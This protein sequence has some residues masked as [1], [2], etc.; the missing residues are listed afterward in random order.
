MTVSRSASLT[1]TSIAGSR[2][3]HVRSA[4]V[5][6]SIAWTYR[7]PRPAASKATPCPRRNDLEAQR[8]L[9]VNVTRHPP[10]RKS[11]QRDRPTHGAAN[12]M[13]HFAP[14]CHVPHPAT[15]T[16][17]VQAQRA[18]QRPVLSTFCRRNIRQLRQDHAR[19]P[20]GGEQREYEGGLHL[21]I[22]CA[23]RMLRH[24][25]Q[26]AASLA[27]ARRHDSA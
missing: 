11:G 26:Q 1:C 22:L 16:P 17:R 13:P 10:S 9:V 23:S 6:S 8:T 15:E 2:A 14:L 25:A 7:R 19:P 4:A 18:F 3:F 20:P 12:K 27:G 5:L 21:V 24:R